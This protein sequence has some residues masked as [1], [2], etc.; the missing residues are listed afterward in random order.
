MKRSIMILLSVA[1]LSLAA[2]PAEAHTMASSTAWARLNHSITRTYLDDY[3]QFIAYRSHS[4]WRQS[5]HRVTCWFTLTFAD[6]G[7]NCGQGY[8]IQHSG[9]W[10]NG[11][12]RTGQGYCGE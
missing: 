12:W 10:W 9:Y 1:A 11:H 4:C 2:A 6:G 8:I 7:Y 5:K 3:G